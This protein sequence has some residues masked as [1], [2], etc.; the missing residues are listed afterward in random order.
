[1]RRNTRTPE[2]KR[3]IAKGNNKILFLRRKFQ[4]IQKIKSLLHTSGRMLEEDYLIIHLGH[5]R[6]QE[7]RRW[8]AK[9]TYLLNKR[10]RR[11]SRQNR[12]S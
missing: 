12:A 10:M 1:M 11:Y 8:F 2:E 6:R 7:N 9:Y 4:H 3:M 5:A